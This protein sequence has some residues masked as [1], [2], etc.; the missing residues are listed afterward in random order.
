MLQ[1]SARLILR[2]EVEQCD[3]D[4][5][6]REPLGQSDHNAGF[7]DSAFAA[8]GKTTRFANAVIARLRCPS[9]SKVRFHGTRSGGLRIRYGWLRLESGHALECRRVGRSGFQRGQFKLR[10][11]AMLRTNFYE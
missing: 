11:L 7:A 1:R 2:I 4:F 3:R 9:G 8:H 5:I 10:L 6:G